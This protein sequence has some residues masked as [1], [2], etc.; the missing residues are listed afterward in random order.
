MIFLPYKFSF[1]L[2]SLLKQGPWAGCESVRHP[3]VD[4]Q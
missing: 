4:I 1:R 2:N 3:L